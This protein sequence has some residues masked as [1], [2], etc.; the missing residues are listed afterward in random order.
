MSNRR[1]YIQFQVYFILLEVRGALNFQEVLN[2]N[3]VIESQS[4][5]G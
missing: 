2:Y 5:H 4:L 1:I 3:E